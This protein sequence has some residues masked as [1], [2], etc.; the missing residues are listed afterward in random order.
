MLTSASIEGEDFTAQVV[1]RLRQLDEIRAFDD[2]ESLEQRYRLIHSEGQQHE[3][4]TV[5]LDMYRFA[6]RFFR[7]RIYQKMDD[8][9]RRILHRQV[10]ECLEA[11]YGEGEL[12]SI[13]S[14]LT[15]HFK[16]AGKRAKA[17]RYA[18]LAAEVEQSRY[19]WA[20]GEH[21]CALGLELVN[22]LRPNRE[23]KEGF[24]PRFVGAIWKRVL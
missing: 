23:T 8:G 15:Q 7:E 19:A 16:A 13:A 9:K 12:M 18:L 11:L 10:G 4:A 6:H 2:L 1:A 5:V 24:E 22:D 21:W 17:A 20:E 14:Q 3:V